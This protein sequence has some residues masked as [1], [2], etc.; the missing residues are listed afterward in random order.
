MDR[1]SGPLISPGLEILPAPALAGGV[2]LRNAMVTSTTATAAAARPW[3]ARAR[4]T[5]A[6]VPTTATAWPSKEAGE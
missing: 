6:P 4:Y 3:P 2:L 5:A 1:R